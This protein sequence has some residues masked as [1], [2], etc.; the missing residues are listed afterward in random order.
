MSLE[1]EE[2]SSIRPTGTCF[3]D[4]LDFITECL[5]T[6]DR[7][8]RLE[9]LVLVHAIAIIP[10]SGVNAGERFAHAWVE[11]EDDSGEPVV[12]QSGLV[13]VREGESYVEAKAYYSAERQ[14]VYETLRVER[15]WRYSLHEAREANQRH[16]TYG[17]WEP[18]LLELCAD[19]KRKRTA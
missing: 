3:D 14:S 8:A 6:E 13:M 11:A 2:G 10:P 16:V 4:A 17:P 5:K 9:T 7:L 15:T 18:E 19:K 1:L 12:W